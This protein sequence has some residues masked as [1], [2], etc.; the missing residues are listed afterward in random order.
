M[1]KQYSKIV[2]IYIYIDCT[3]VYLILTGNQSFIY[4]VWNIGGGRD[5]KI[6]DFLKEGWLP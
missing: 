4:F 2:Y 5:W 6:A 3:V 1:R